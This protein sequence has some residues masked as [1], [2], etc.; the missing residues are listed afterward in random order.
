MHTVTAALLLAARAGW[1]RCRSTPGAQPSQPAGGASRPPEVEANLV[2]YGRKYWCVEC[3]Y[4]FDKM[5]NWES[6][7]GGRRHSTQV[8]AGT[9]G[10]RVRRRAALQ[11]RRRLKRR[12]PRSRRPG[13][14]RPTWPRSQCADPH[15]SIPRSRMTRR[16]ARARA[17]VTLLPRR[18]VRRGRDLSAGQASRRRRRARS[19]R[20]R[21]RATRAVAP[22]SALVAVDARAPRLLRVKELLESVGVQGRRASVGLAE[23]RRRRSGRL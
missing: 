5:K 3:N 13:A 11:Q 12:R 6:H 1:W 19:T 10:R 7:V 9:R 23:Q 8:A 20:D 2:A 15:I 14:R 18:C 22:P 16:P 4:G 21:A 17:P